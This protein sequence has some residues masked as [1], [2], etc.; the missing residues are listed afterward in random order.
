VARVQL[1]AVRWLLDFDEQTP[2]VDYRGV[3]TGDLAVRLVP[4]LVLPGATT[5][6]TA[7]ADIAF[8]PK[9]RPDDGNY[10][11]DDSVAASALDADGWPAMGE[12]E[13]LADAPPGSG[14][15]LTVQLRHASGLPRRLLAP[16]R[17]LYV[18]FRFPTAFLPSSSSSISSRLHTRDNEVVRTAR[19]PLPGG[20]GNLC[21]PIRTAHTLQLAVTPALVDF[22]ATA[23]L[24]FEVWLSV[25]PPGP[26]AE[27]SASGSSRNREGGASGV[28][29]GYRSSDRGLLFEGG[30]GDFDS[31]DSGE[32]AGSFGV[33]QGH[34]GRSS[35]ESGSDND[36]GL[37]PHGI[38]V[39]R[40]QPTARQQRRRQRQW[41]RQ[42]QEGEHAFHGNGGWEG[43]PSPPHSPPSGG[44][45]SAGQQPPTAAE[46][47]A[48]VADAA[49]LRAENAAL[50]AQLERAL[51]LVATR[52]AQASSS[53]STTGAAAVRAAAELEEAPG[54]AATL[55]TP[56]PVV[57][58]KSARSRSRERTAAR[59]R[60][61][62]A[63][64]LDRDLNGA[65]PF[66]PPKGSPL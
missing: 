30:S 62:D 10:P 48:V 53:N 47:A 22:A 21:A 42:R 65:P 63:Q 59:L 2:L 55:P 23:A 54:R 8:L 36:E 43:S 5:G 17:S 25:D 6:A 24:A 26:W 50:L 7:A 19:V 38:A 45:F 51:Q 60:L 35:S 41:Q 40:N 44:S 32:D 33:A 18:S 11:D 3:R 57:V 66:G 1:E 64:S 37:P 61:G 12:Y 58:G 28:P 52:D 14:L 34:R 16:A 56:A 13:D 39:V 31:E 4:A 49:R 20:H 46:Y 27:T 15:N 9:G 29:T